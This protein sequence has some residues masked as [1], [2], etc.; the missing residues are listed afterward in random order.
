MLLF[1]W[2]RRGCQTCEAKSV[3]LGSRLQH[4]DACW[5]L[6][7]KFLLSKPP[8]PSR[9]QN[10]IGPSRACKI[11]CNSASMAPR[12]RSRQRQVELLRLLRLFRALWDLWAPARARHPKRPSLA[13]K[14]QAT[15]CLTT[16][17]LCHLADLSLQTF[18]GTYQQSKTCLFGGQLCPR[19]RRLP[20]S[21]ST[22]RS[23]PGKSGDQLA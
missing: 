13:R 10:S 6:L 7:S 15:V 5:K 22:M 11:A 4:V 14:Q 3:G 1:V 12:P 17:K 9:P 16:P 8:I 20:L 21:F 19:S 2:A 23:L 18:C